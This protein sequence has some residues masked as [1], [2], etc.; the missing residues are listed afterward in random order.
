MLFNLKFITN[1]IYLNSD[2]YMFHVKH[3]FITIVLKKYLICVC[4]N[5]YL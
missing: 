5:I 2:K 3:V 1:K 4:L